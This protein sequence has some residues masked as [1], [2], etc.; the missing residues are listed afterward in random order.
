MIF[1]FDMQ[2]GQEFEC[3]PSAKY[4]LHHNMECKSHDLVLALESTGDFGCFDACILP[5]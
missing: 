3:F 1:V 5:N 2:Q 4:K